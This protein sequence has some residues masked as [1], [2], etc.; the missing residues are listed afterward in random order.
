MPKGNIKG[1]KQVMAGNMALIQ[2]GNG[3]KKGINSNK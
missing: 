3:A 1:Q 2:K